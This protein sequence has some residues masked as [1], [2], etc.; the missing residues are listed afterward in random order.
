MCFPCSGIKE[1]SLKKIR[2]LPVVLLLFFTAPALAERSPV[3]LVM[4]DSLSAAY[5]IPADSGW[6][7]LLEQRLQQQGLNHQGQ[8]WQVVNASVSGETTSGGLTRLPALLRQHQPRIV[9]LELGANDGLRGQPI[10]RIRDNLQ[11]M[12]QLSRAE[13][14]EVLLIGILLPP[15]YG[16]RYTSQFAAIYPELARTQRLPLVPFLLDGVADQPHLMQQDGLHPTA[17]AQHRLLDNV[18]P[19][20][21]PLLR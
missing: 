1:S 9:L 4:G 10:P 2:W 7:S 3:L 17:E 12:V 5:N 16:P 6:V 18:W 13:G 15:N 20:L 14:A 19:H 21:Q 8:P 11:Q